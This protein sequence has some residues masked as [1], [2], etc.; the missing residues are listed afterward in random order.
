MA[1]HTNAS[2]TIRVETFSDAV[3]A[4]SI[5]LLGLALKVPRPGHEP[6]LLALARQWPALL[7]L[8]TSFMTIGIVWINHHRVFTHIHVVSHGLLLLNG[9]LLLTVSLIP[10]TSDLVAAYIGYEGSKTAAVVYA[11]NLVFVTGSFNLLWRHATRRRRLV[12]HHI[13]PAMVR[14]INLQYGFGPLLYV[15]ALLAA[16][17]SAV[18]SILLDV[19]FAVFFALPAF[20]VSD[21]QP[22]GRAASSAHGDLASSG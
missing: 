3:F 16:T 1:R 15:L 10:F 7:A 20:T 6:L 22:A 11:A 13:S 12:D 17:Y 9:L 21:A 8:V 4:I 5:T 2:E 18:G 19:A 14:R